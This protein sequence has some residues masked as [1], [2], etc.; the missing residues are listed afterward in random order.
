[1]HTSKSN[2]LIKTPLLKLPEVLAGTKTSRSFVYAGVKDGTFPAPLKIGKRSVAWT[3]DS[4]NSWIASKSN[5][6]QS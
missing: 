1:M 5:G 2:G 4:I 3:A 6:G